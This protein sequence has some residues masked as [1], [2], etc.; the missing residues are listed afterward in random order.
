[1][2]LTCKLC[3]KSFFAKE[4]EFCSMKCYKEYINYLQKKQHDVIKN[5]RLASKTIISIQNRIL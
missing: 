1:M 3:T 4:A 5:N 2:K